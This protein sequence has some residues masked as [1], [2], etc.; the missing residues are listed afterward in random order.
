MLYSYNQPIPVH[1]FFLRYLPC[2]V[3]SLEYMKTKFFVVE[4]KKMK[5]YNFPIGSHRIIL[6][7]ISNF[8]LGTI[9]FS[10]RLF[11]SLAV[12]SIDRG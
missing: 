11:V 10:T 6:T 9:L 7:V 1:T 8:K 3:I 2:E 12:S 5:C 4:K